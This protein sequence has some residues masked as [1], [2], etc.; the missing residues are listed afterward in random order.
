MKAFISIRRRAAPA[1]PTR[2]ERSSDFPMLAA[3]CQSTPLVAVLP[4]ALN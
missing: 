2:G 3:C 1:K 4:W